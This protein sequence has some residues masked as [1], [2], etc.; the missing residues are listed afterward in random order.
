MIDLY[1]WFALI[2]S[3]VLVVLF[4]WRLRGPLRALRLHRNE[5]VVT[6]LLTTL[7]FL[8]VSIGLVISSV[9]LFVHEQALIVAGLGFIRGAL[10]V[11]GLT[12]IFTDAEVRSSPPD[13]DT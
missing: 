3:V 4:S 5:R 11:G 13:R 9:S 12:L 2:S 6:R 10:L 7:M 8:A 1:P